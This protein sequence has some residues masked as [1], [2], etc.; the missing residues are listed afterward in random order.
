M[1]LQ[2]RELVVVEKALLTTDA[3]IEPAVRKSCKETT[4][5]PLKGAGTISDWYVLF[6]HVSL[7]ICAPRIQK[8]GKR[9]S[10]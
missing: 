6:F 10:H 1:V 5:S 8:I 9:T 7:F 2:P 3:R 4:T